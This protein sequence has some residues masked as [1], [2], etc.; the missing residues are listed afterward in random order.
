ME[1]LVEII[2]VDEETIR[3]MEG[4]LGGY[5]VSLDAPVGEDD[6]S[7]S[8]S[9]FFADQKA[10]PEE[11]IGNAEERR[12]NGAKLKSAILELPEREQEIIQRR[13][14]SHSKADSFL[15]KNLP[16]ILFQSSKVQQ[17]LPIY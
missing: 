16:R 8:R 15:S 3:S 6:D 14:L 17:C 10:S 13:H 12:K 2:G 1:R 5:D 7:A 9:A 4:R 11:T